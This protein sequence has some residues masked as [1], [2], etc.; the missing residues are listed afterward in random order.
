MRLIGARTIDELTPDMVDANAIHSHIGLTPQICITR[1][2]SHVV[3]ISHPS[4]L[5]AYPRRSTP[6]PCPVQEQAVKGAVISP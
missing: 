4:L 6:C 1:Y 2:V 3:L 5:I